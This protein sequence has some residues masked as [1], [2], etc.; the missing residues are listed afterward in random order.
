MLRSANTVF[1]LKKKLTFGA[2]RSDTIGVYVNGGDGYWWRLYTGQMYIEGVSGDV[3][4][5]GNGV[6]NAL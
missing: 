4:L 3:V 2:N 5:D 6:L 1:A